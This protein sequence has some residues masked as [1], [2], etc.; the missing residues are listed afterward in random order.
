MQAFADHGFKLVVL[1]AL[2]ETGSFTAELEALKS[3]PAISRKLAGEEAYG[4]TIEEMARF[5]RDVQLSEADLAQVERI[6]FDGGNDIYHLIRPFWSGESD[7]FEVLSVDGFEK[8]TNLKSAF[9]ASMISD[10]QLDRLKQ[11]GIR[12]D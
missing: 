9:Y 10:E 11:A 3:D 4:E 7:E 8:L 12:I 2:L 5:F 1:E 6:C